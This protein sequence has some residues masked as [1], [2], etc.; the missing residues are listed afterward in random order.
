[1]SFNMLTATDELSR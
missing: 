1:M